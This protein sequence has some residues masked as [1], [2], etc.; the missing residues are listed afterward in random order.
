M[1][2]L[3]LLLLPLAFAAGT[4]L[5]QAGKPADLQPLPAVP[6]PP[7]EIVPFDDALEPQVTIRKREGDT[8]EEYRRDGR[9]Y[10]IKVTP[11]HGVPYY[12]VDTEGDGNFNRME[13]LDNKVRVPMWI[14]KTF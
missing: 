12:L 13:S 4:A 8:V 1:R 2:H 6:P 14:L 5:A 7:P 10:M 3:R 11:P 9:L